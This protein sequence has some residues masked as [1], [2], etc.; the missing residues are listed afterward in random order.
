M[1]ISNKTKHFSFGFRDIQTLYNDIHQNQMP[2]RCHL[3]AWY[4]YEEDL[5]GFIW[6]SVF[7]GTSVVNTFLHVCCSLTNCQQ[8][9]AEV[10]MNAGGNEF[11]LI[12]AERMLSLTFYIVVVVRTRVFQPWHWLKSRLV[13]GCRCTET[14]CYRAEMQQSFKS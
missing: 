9:Y 10:N 8:K 2:F 5:F 13:P 7:F 3:S 12:M 4:C 14:E 6:Y 11:S 1:K